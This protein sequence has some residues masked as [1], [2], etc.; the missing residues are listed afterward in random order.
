M[1]YRIGKNIPSLLMKQPCMAF[2]VFLCF[3][4][5]LP[6]ATEVCLHC[7]SSR[8]VIDVVRSGDAGAVYQL[9]RALRE[10]HMAR[11]HDTRFCLVDFKKYIEI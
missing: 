5:V 7:H 11:V 9:A 10:T 1:P 2:D 8:R 6:F 4:R 3:L